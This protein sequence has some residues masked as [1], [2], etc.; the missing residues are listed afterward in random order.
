M[1]LL[2]C[3]GIGE[4]RYDTCSLLGVQRELLEPASDAV[5]HVLELLERMTEQSLQR[6]VRL[7]GCDKSLDCCKWEA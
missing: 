4:S 6:S 3:R 1:Q 7:V 2:A 5:S